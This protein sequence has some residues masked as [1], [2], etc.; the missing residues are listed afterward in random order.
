MND[1]SKMSET[2]QVAPKLINNDVYTF[3]FTKEQLSL[4]NLG[5]KTLKT[6]RE[7]SLRCITK[8]RED[9][10]HSDNQRRIRKKKDNM[11]L[12]LEIPPPVVELPQEPVINKLEEVIKTAEVVKNKVKALKKTK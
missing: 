6:Q 10:N 5:L 11:I 7:I 2:I 3:E 1:K 4:I 12:L 9:E 8:K